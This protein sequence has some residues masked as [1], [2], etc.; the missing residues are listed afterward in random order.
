MLLD[1]A[2]II[3]CSLLAFSFIFLARERTFISI[4]LYITALTLLLYNEYA[5]IL[6]SIVVISISTIA[7]VYTYITI[8]MIGSGL[9][10]YIPRIEIDIARYLRSILHYVTIVVMLSIIGPLLYEVLLKLNLNLLLVYI[11]STAMVIGIAFLIHRALRRGFELYIYLI[12]LAL[13]IVSLS[14]GIDISYEFKFLDR[15]L[16]ILEEVLKG[17]G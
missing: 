15:E 17:I 7:Y 4:S 2:K 5:D 3:L 1:L 11:F 9:A 16:R 10:P 14:L 12:A 13:C 6:R 8:S